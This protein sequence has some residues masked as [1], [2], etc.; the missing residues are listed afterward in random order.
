MRDCEHP[1]SLS[2]AL[3]GWLPHSDE[4][5]ENRAE[6]SA[7]HLLATAEHEKEKR[8]VGLFGKS[9]PIKRLSP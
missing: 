6:E 4:S 9:L 2:A 5:N 8:K 7:T 1:E 3:L